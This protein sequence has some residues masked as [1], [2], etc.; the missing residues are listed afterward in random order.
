[1]ALYPLSSLLLTYNRPRLPRSPHTSLL[2]TLFTFVVSLVLIGGNIAL[3]PAT[4]GYF[5]AYAT[6]IGGGIWLMSRKSEVLVF[7]WWVLSRGNSSWREKGCE[8]LV[9]GMKKVRSGAV[10]VFVETDEVRFG[11]LSTSVWKLNLVMIQKINRLFEMIFYVRKNEDTMNVKLV[12]F[13]H[14]IEDIP[15]ELEAN[16]KS[17]ILFAKAFDGISADFDN[18]EVLDEAFPSITVVS[19]SSLTIPTFTDESTHAGPHL[20]PR[21]IL[22]LPRLSRSRTA[23]HTSYIMF[24]GMPQY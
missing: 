19:L 16:Y 9:R 4:I 3:A 1:M 21:N 7:A 2:F 18:L 13:Y 17:E 8:R 6:V 23:Q 14:S 24:H 22:P 15:S 12:H 10:V 20:R 5:A 11:H